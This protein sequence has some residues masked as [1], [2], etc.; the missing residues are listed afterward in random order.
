[1]KKYNQFVLEVGFRELSCQNFAIN[2]TL[3]K[4]ISKTIESLNKTDV[5]YKE[6]VEISQ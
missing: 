5:Y 4:E 3:D 6:Y 2:R 1:M